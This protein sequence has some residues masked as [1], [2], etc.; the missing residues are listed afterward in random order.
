LTL[1]HCIAEAR[2]EAVRLFIATTGRVP[3][4]MELV[5]FFPDP[6]PDNQGDDFDEFE[7]LF[8]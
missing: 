5:T 4:T 6:L 8:R 2:A 3:A 7:D 1:Q